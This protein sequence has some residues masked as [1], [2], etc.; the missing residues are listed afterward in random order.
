MAG[1]AIQL[2]K[3]SETLCRAVLESIRCSPPLTRRQAAQ[4]FQS[5]CCSPRSSSTETRGVPN[6]VLLNGIEANRV[7][8]CLPAERQPTRQRHLLDGP[9]ITGRQE[10][11]TPAVFL[12][13]GQHQNRPPA[14]KG[15]THP[16]MEKSFNGYSGPRCKTPPLQHFQP[17][18][19]DAVKPQCYSLQAM[20]VNH[21]RAHISRH[22]RQHSQAPSTACLHQAA[23]GLFLKVLASEGAENKQ[24]TLA[25]RY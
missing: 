10:N 14:G 17:P 15:L 1:V 3:R 11:A 22:M 6:A 7:P 21:R 18:S 19:I 4:T 25:L 5:S 2:G 13:H 9:T 20:A 16:R 12:A 24:P 8:R 23:P